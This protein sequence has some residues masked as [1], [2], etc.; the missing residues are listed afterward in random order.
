MI[1]EE[2]WDEEDN[3][4]KRAMR[5]LLLEDDEIDEFEDAFMEGYSDESRDCEDK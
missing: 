5:A 3:V 4:Y 1:F 2:D